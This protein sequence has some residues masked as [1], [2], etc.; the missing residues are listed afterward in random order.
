MSWLFWLISV[1]LRLPHDR[2]GNRV[3]PQETLVQ[4]LKEEDQVCWGGGLDS[5]W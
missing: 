5:T 4:L 1:R 2:F 3:F